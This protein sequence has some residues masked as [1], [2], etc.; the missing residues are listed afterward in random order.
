MHVMLSF[1]VECHDL[2]WKPCL[3]PTCR[4]D[5]C[6]IGI[7]SWQASFANPA[8]WVDSYLP[9]PCFPRVSGRSRSSGSQA[10][11][12]PRPRW[13]AVRADPPSLL[14]DQPYISKH[15]GPLAPGGSHTPALITRRSS[16]RVRDD[17]L[18]QCKRQRPELYLPGFRD[19]ESHLHTWPGDQ[20]S[21]PH[22]GCDISVH[23]QE[24]STH[25]MST[26]LQSC[27]L[28]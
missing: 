13:M 23:Q 17:G 25:N 10:R 20:L 7:S 28:D 27:Q 8:P 1:R 6:V 12:G 2:S 26:L 16:R 14:A 11:R 21:N 24:G 4:D 5:V 19:R 9:D 3:S 15:L 18:R 22:I